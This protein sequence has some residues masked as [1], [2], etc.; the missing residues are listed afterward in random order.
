MGQLDKTCW[1]DVRSS[2]CRIESWGRAW[3]AGSQTR[4]L[5]AHV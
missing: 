5:L 1:V 4:L 2:M 3:G